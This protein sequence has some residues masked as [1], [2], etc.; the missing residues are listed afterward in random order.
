[1]T[2]EQL[3][4]FRRRVRAWLSS[5]DIP[6][7]PDDLDARFAVLRR[8]QR[9]LYRAG[10]LGLTW[11]PEWG[12]SGLDSRYQQALIE[13]L[14]N[15]RAPQ[16]AG[17]IGL[18]VV[19]PSIGRFGTERQRSRY[20]PPILSGD[21]IWCQ[22]FSEPEA[23]SDLASVK[24]T[25]RLESGTY[26]VNGQKVWTSWAHVADWCALLVR[27]S[28]ADGRRGLSYLIVDMRSR[29]ITVRPL[30]QISGDSEF[31]EVFFENVTVPASN[32]VGL[33]GDGWAIAMDTLSHER[34]TY[35]GRRYAEV[36]AALGDACDS[37]AEALG[38]DQAAVPERLFET[39]GE[40]KVAEQVLHAQAVATLGRSVTSGASP[41][42]S[43]DKLVLARTEQDIF[44]SLRSLLGPFLN[45]CGE[46]AWGL[47][48]LAVGRDYL[49][50]RA[51]SIYGGT[52]QIQKNI[53]AERLLGVPR[54]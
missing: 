13:E 40:A 30:R 38:R 3:S 23:G 15:V 24:T 35:I 44:E 33:P 6:S 34:G 4:A 32:L 43:V 39:V 50:G 53:V 47:R 9:D 42:D 46:T 1:M 45:E 21:E 41:L 11:P 51:A 5:A 54:D 14:V 20:L 10:L 25:A 12:G 22:G 31:N 27:T 37:L 49:Y 26:I 28:V 17:L 48:S 2:D 52:S 16:P 19:G 18:D 7:L 8:W 29:G 36:S